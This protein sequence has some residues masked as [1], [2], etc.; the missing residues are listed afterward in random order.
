MISVTTQLTAMAVRAPT[1]IAPLPRDKNP[2]QQ[3]QPKRQKQ[4]RLQ[5][6]QPERS[7]R[8][9]RPGPIIAKKQHQAQQQEQGSLAHDHALQRGR[10]TNAQ[11]LEQRA[12]SPIHL[13]QRLD[14]NQQNAQH[15]Q[16][17]RQRSDARSKESQRQSKGQTPRRIPHVIRPALAIEAGAAFEI[18]HRHRIV[19]IS[20]MHQLLAGRPVDDVIARPRQM[21]DHRHHA[22]KQRSQRD[23]HPARD[24][25]QQLGE[26]GLPFWLGGNGAVGHC[27][28]SN[29]A[30]RLR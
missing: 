22:Q 7:S 5:R 28:H 20:V 10:K 18:A 25:D 27:G 16:R 17:P 9:K 13:P 24:A 12:R 14:A 30:T 1:R 8:P 3:H 11:P 19:G 6:A 26:V 15:Q 23:R 2:E 21:T 4:M 29:N